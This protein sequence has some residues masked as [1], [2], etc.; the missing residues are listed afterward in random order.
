MWRSTAGARGADQART[1][2]AKAVKATDPARKAR[3]EKAGLA[4]VLVISTAAFSKTLLLQARPIRF[5]S[6][7][8]KNRMNKW[9]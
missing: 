6:L 7:D 1:A 8:G 9:F 4:G 5:L 2:E 3:R